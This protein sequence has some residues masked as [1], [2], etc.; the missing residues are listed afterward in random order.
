MKIGVVDH[1][2][3]NTKQYD[4]IMMVL[5]KIKNKNEKIKGESVENTVTKSTKIKG[6]IPRRC[7]CN[8]RSH[9]SSEI[10]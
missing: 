10:Q 1:E 7:G 8:F 6:T 9:N 4:L 2:Y 3:F 5:E